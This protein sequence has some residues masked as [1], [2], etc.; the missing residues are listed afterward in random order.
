[1]LTEPQ[2]TELVDQQFEPY[3][4]DLGA[5]LVSNV[6]SPGLAFHIDQSASGRIR[7][8]NENEWRPVAVRVLERK[9]VGCN[10]CVEERNSNQLKLL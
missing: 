4:A 6:T 1:M 10:A 7:E 8:S 2:L 3:S 5:L 9:I